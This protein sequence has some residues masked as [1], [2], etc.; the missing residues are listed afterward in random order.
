MHSSPESLPSVTS[1]IRDTSSVYNGMFYT[2]FTLTYF[3]SDSM[4]AGL[5]WP[6]CAAS[7]SYAWACLDASPED[8][9]LILLK[10]WIILISFILLKLTP[11]NTDLSSELTHGVL[12]LAL[13]P[14]DFV[15][16]LPCS[17]KNIHTGEII[18]CVIGSVHVLFW[19]LHCRGERGRKGRVECHFQN[20]AHRTFDIINT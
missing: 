17:W 6:G 3:S 14:P 11:F 15:S 18:S 1:A 20:K 12:N 13:K 8:V 2:S 19:N 4:P 10:Y 5:L 16:E 7:P 9:S